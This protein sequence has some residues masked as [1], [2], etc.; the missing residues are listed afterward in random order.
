[1]A[2]E[3]FT[4]GWSR[5]CRDRLNA[6]GTFRALAPDWSD[7]VVLSM[8]PDP[9]RGLGTERAVYLDLH[10]GECRDAREATAADLA[11]APIVLSAAPDTWR[12][13]LESGLDPV[14][15][16]MRGQ[17]RLQRGNL[18]MLARHAAAAREMV[19]AAAEV[20]G[21]FPEGDAAA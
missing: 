12:Q 17:L 5:A 1:M 15:A 10:G 11:S 18:L 20:H 7:P 19:A 16:V 6:R 4:D 14:A 9:A 8:S 3:V 2:Y 21:S 13:L